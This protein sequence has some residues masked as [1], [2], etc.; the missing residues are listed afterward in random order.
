MIT[1]QEYMQIVEFTDPEQADISDINLIK[2]EW[3]YY[4]NWL[5][6]NKKYSVGFE[7][8]QDTN[9]S[10]LE[11]PDGSEIEANGYIVEFV[12]PKGTRPTD[13]AGGAS[14]VIYKQMMLAI[15]KLIETEHVDYLAFSGQ[16]GKMDRLYDRFVK[17]FLGDR[18]TW[19]NYQILMNNTFLNQIA[20]K[21]PS[22]ANSVAERLLQ[23]KNMRQ[24]NLMFQ[25]QQ[26]DKSRIQKRTSVS[27]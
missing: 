16:T 13:L 11:L 18:Y 17:K 2:Q 4:Y 19:Y 1:F 21:H 26:D 14:L 5:Y 7:K 6:N 22:S 15:R 10:W 9:P 24:Q 27:V 3:G 8:V 23:T 25:K 20:L 12:G